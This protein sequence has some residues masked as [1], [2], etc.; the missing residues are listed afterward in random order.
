MKMPI[1][2][3]WFVVLVVLA[4]WMEVIYY[5]SKEDYQRKHENHVVE[6]K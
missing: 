3:T 6:R 2:K 5:Q 4:C 1:S